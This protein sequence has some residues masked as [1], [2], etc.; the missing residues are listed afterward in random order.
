MRNIKINK[1]QIVSVYY[2]KQRLSA[3][4]YTEIPEKRIFFG[5]I[6]DTPARSGYCKMEWGIAGLYRNWINEKDFKEY[7][8][9]LVEGKVYT[10]PEI[11]IG[12]SNKENFRKTFETDEEMFKWMENNLSGV[13]L[14]EMT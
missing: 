1:Q 3:Y 8:L 11:S 14:I 2:F 10:K 12:M 9:K 6:L 13:Q 4:K 5:W 7:S